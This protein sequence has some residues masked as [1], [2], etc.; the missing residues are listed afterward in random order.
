[1]GWRMRII[2]EPKELIGRYVAAKQKHAADWGLYTAFGLINTDD[3]LVAGI[4]FNGYTPPSIMM[5]IAADQMTP[6]LIA[7]AMHYA[8]VKSDCKRI[9]GIIDQNNDKSCRFAR[10][11]GAKL[12]GIMRDASKTGNLCIYGLLREDAQK[13]LKPKYLRKLEAS[14]AL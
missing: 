5:H 2:S 12:E 8:F 3:E 10:S 7:T 4:V 1:M 11:L 14:W 13:W 6:G 9:T